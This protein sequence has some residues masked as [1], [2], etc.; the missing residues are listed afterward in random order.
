VFERSA[1]FY[2][3]IYGAMGKDYEGESARLSALIASRV[4]GAF[5]LLD[6]ACGTGRHVE[7]L[8]A[9]F[10]C[11]GV[12]LD[13]NM[14]AVARSR[15]PDTTFVTADMTELDLGRTFDVVTCLF[16]SIGY[17]VT[18]DRLRRAAER[19]AAHLRPGGLLVIEPWVLREDW[20]PGRVQVLHAEDGGTHVVRM[21][22]STSVDDVSVL[23]A[24]YLVGSSSGIE[25][26]TE[27]HRLG[28]FSRA[29]Y[30]DAVEEAGLRAEWVDEGISGRGLLVGSAPS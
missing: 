28:L 1:R 23:H 22:L 12:D 4:P 15:C 24:H 2:D 26:L 16:S 9:S 29:Q 7:Y 14:L 6:V 20:F 27:E 18:L 13:D 25:H 5:T 21:M 30:L 17:V 10:E 11:V 19:M 8:S 3:A